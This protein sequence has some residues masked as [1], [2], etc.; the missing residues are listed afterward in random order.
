MVL[1][2]P[3]TVISDYEKASINALTSVFPRVEH[4]GCLFHFAQSLYR[5]VVKLGFNLNI[6]TISHSI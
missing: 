1:E 5:K 2:E 4:Q 3:R 6:T